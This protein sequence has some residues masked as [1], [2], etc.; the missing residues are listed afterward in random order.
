MDQR[1]LHGLLLAA[2]VAL[3][4]LAT[5]TSAQG[6]PT[7]VPAFTQPP[8]PSTAGGGL[9]DERGDRHA[10]FAGGTVPAVAAVTLT[11]DN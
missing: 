8:P 7:P 9:G 1:V 6:A 5:A 4:A 10:V 11:L 2:G 3:A